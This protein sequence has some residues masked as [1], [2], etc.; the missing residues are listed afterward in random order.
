MCALNTHIHDHSFSWLGK[1]LSMKYNK[2]K[3]NCLLK[4]VE[5]CPL[6]LPDR[7]LCYKN[8]VDMQKCLE[9]LVYVIG[10]MSLSFITSIY[11]AIVLNK[12]ID[13]KQ[14]TCICVLS[15]HVCVL[16]DHVCVLS[17]HV[18]VC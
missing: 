15:D 7:K 17:D 2:D 3:K 10:V 18:Y 4:E 13:V 16:S 12:E 9:R 8:S 1:G 5:L 14:E 11:I 6:G